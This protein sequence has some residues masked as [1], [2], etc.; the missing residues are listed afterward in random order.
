V[1]ASTEI[2]NAVNSIL[3]D[4][5]ESEITESEVIKK[6]N[7]LKKK[8]GNILKKANGKIADGPHKSFFEKLMEWLGFA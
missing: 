4:G 7:Q 2:F 6:L 8:L 5:V 3:M 1:Q